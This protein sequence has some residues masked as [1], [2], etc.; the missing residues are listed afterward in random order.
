MEIALHDDP[1]DPFVESLPGGSVLLHA[2]PDCDVENFLATQTGVD[3][4][5]SA[6]LIDLWKN[7]NTLRTF[8]PRD[9][10]VLVRRVDSL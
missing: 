4:Q 8:E 3:S 6:G 2:H 5:I 10:Y 7:P 9:G 1:I